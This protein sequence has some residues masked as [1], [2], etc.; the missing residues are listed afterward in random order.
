LLS[1]EIADLRSDITR[2]Y[3]TEILETQDQ[4]LRKAGGGYGAD[5]LALYEA[6][7]TDDQVQACVNQLIDG[8]NKLEFE[9]V[10]GER[11]GQAPSDL[12][13]KARD[14][15]QEIVDCLDLK[16]I[17]SEMFWTK[18]FGYGVAE[19]LPIRDGDRIVLDFQKGGIRVRN[20]RR[21]RFDFN[22]NV[23]L[24]TPDNYY[25]GE[26]VHP[27]RVWVSKYGADNSD[28]PYGLGDASACYWWVVFKKGGVKSW[29]RF[30][31]EFSSPTA[32][33][34]HPP[35]LSEDSKAQIDQA[36]QDLF[37]GRSTTLS[38]NLEIS[39]LETS[40][41]ATSDYGALVDTCNR[42]IARAILGATETT[43]SSQSSGY[44]QAKVHQEVLSGTI[45]AID[46]II[47]EPFTRQVIP[48]LVEWNWREQGVVYPILRRKGQKDDLSARAERDAKLFNLGIRLKPEAVS[49]IYGEEYSTPVSET[50]TVLLNGAQITSL[51]Q[52]VKDAAS[53]ALPIATARELMIA[54][55]GVPE[56][57]ADKVVQPLLDKVATP[58][59]EPPAEE[60]LLSVSATEEKE[61]PNP[62]LTEFAEQ[63]TSE[64]AAQIAE[65]LSAR[66]AK[67][68]AK[69]VKP[70][71]EALDRSDGDLLAFR[72]ALSETYSALEG[73]E[74]TSLLA[75]ALLTAK[76]AGTFEAEK[77]QET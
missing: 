14:F 11:K 50:E 32:I 20:R 60:P 58:T 73:K 75:E 13:L 42:A 19:L 71:A 7:K 48:R 38:N 1:S 5:A 9:L 62:V 54:A 59:T 56:A 17:I 4:V 65:N 63:E 43:E 57:I 22:L 10:P 21:F 46:R 40:R 72:E 77:E 25:P 52:L 44:A 51:S 36:A 29:L 24:L 67:A 30:L 6:L 45:T 64:P 70:I 37:E 2:G 12:D 39:F 53:G 35:N 47:F 68:L 76:L 41:N 55:L 34:R 74:L 69:L 3:L 66:T 15:V 23:R 18:F 26:L 27:S 33:F 8:A 61:S 28:E 49:K 31:R 16:S